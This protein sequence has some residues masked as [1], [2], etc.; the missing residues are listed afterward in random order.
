[1]TDF[2]V[3]TSIAC[4]TF[5]FSICM[6]VVVYCISVVI[7]TSIVIIV[8]NGTNV[9]VASLVGSWYLSMLSEGSSC[10]SVMSHPRSGIL[11]YGMA[12]LPSSCLLTSY[13]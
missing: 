11:S 10:V 12:F 9:V 2:V 1:M 13:N 4:T 8:C 5:L 6:P 3:T 7:S